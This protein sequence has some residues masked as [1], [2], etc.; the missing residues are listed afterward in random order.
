M[1]NQPAPKSSKVWWILGGVVFVAI[2]AANG[3]SG[4][5]APSAALAPAAQTADVAQQIAQ[6]TAQPQV[7]LQQDSLSNDN[8][9][10]NSDG[11]TIH[12]PAY[13]NSG[14]PAGATA[15][16]RDGTYSFSQHRSGTCSHHGGV[17][18]WL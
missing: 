6:P 10:T 14:V 18:T 1:D 17:A 13:S 3:N 4:T 12:S 11:D 16:C 9:Y 8:Y 15:Q 5:P 7:Q 2:A